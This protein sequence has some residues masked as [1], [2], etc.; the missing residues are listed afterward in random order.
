MFYKKYTTTVSQLLVKAAKQ[1]NLEVI[2][3]F[4]FELRCY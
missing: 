1:L 4:K 2:G 3:L